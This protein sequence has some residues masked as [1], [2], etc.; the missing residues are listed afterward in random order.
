MSASATAARQC[1]KPE[2]QDFGQI[3]HL[4]GQR[5]TAEITACNCLSHLAIKMR[6]CRQQQQRQQQQAQV[7]HRPQSEPS[8]NSCSLCLRLCPGPVRL[9][10]KLP[11]LISR[12]NL[13]ALYCIFASTFT[14]P[15][16]RRSLVWSSVPAW[17]QY[18]THFPSAFSGTSPIS[19]ARQLQP[20]PCAVF[21]LGLF[22][23][24]LLPVCPL[25]HTLLATYFIWSSC[26]MKCQA[27]C[28]PALTQAA[29]QRTRLAAKGQ[30]MVL[31]DKQLLP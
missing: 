11:R 2:P 16:Q 29:R 13:C 19:A 9:I 20:Q 18:L 23:F 24:P 22:T 4:R 17:L 28:C 12:V 15:G 8:P 7:R 30:L 31:C 3:S 6:F 5:V 14:R 26:L 27:C 25:L 1:G 21:G 10:F